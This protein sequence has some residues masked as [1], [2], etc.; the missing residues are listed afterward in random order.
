MFNSKQKSTRTPFKNNR[1]NIEKHANRIEPNQSER[2]VIKKEEGEDELAGKGRMSFLVPHG[3]LQRLDSH[4]R[5]AIVSRFLFKT[6][7]FEGRQVWT[8]VIDHNWE[9]VR[10]N[11]NELT[12][13]KLR[14][15]N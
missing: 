14:R 8:F 13:D 12:G 1:Q 4:L 5:R 10:E 15:F 6:P 3:S 7:S 9:E 11:N 2:N